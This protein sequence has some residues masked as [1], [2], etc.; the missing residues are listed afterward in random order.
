MSGGCIRSLGALGC[1]GF[2]RRSNIFSARLEKVER[3]EDMER[4]ELLAI[5]EEAKRSGQISLNLSLRQI[6]EL[7]ES[8]GELT[9]L[10]FLSLGN[11]R[12]T[13]LPESI[14]ELTNLTSLNLGR[15][16]LTVLP[17]SI[18]QLTSLTSLSLWNNRLTILP[19]SMGELINLKSLSLWNNCL[20]ILPESIGELINL[21]SINLTSNRIIVLPESIGELTNL[22]SLNLENNHLTVLSE[23]IGQLSALK[24]FILRNNQLVALPDSIGKLSNL[25]SLD[26]SSNQLIGLPNSIRKLTNLN[27]LRCSYNQLRELPQSIGELT[28]LILLDLDNND[29]IELPESI[30]ELTAL[31]FLS[32]LSNHIEELPKSVRNLQKIT[33]LSFNNRQL[34]ILPE[35]VSQLTSLRSLDLKNNELISIP[36][37]IKN[38]TNLT[39]LDLS[40]NELKSF[41]ES[42]IRLT[43]LASLHL[44]NIHLSVLPESIGELTNLAYLDLCYNQLTALPDSIGQLINLTH[45]NLW[46]NQLI[47]L[48]DSIGSLVKLVDLE[49]TSNQLTKLPETI[50]NLQKLRKLK[51]T[52]NQLVT[53]PESIV[54]LQNLSVLTIT[55]NKLDL[56]VE[57]TRKRSPSAILEFLRQQKEEGT[58]SIYEAKLLIIGEPGAGKTSL[59]NKLINSSYELKLEGSKN[60]EKSTEGIDVLHFDFPHSSG[61]AFRINL[62]DFGGQEIYHATHQFFLTKRSLYLL[63]ADT[64]QDNTDFNY[65]LE[66]VELLSESSPTLII[67][68]EKQDRPCQVNENQLYG[69][70]PNQLKGILPTNLATNRGLSQILTD[71]QHHISQLPHIGTPL[72]KTWVRVREAL[73]SDTRNYITKTEFLDLCNTHGFKRKEDT[74]QLSEYLHDLGVCLHFQDDPI[75]KNWIILKPE[76]GTTAVYTVL[77]TPSVQKALGHFTQTDLVMIWADD[78]YTDMRDELLQLMK[79]FKLCYEIP[80]RPRTYITPQLLSPNQPEYDW[81]SNDN[82][83]LRYKYEFMPKGMLTRFTVEMH[84]LIDGDLVWK[85]GVILSDGNARAE[86]IEAYY[87]NEI[88]IRI[89]GQLKKRLLEKIRHEFDKIHNSYNKPEDPP[90]DHRLRYQEYI[91]CNCSTCKGSQTPHAYALKRLEERLKND[92]QEIECDISYTM[93]SVRDLIDDAIGQSLSNPSYDVDTE[94]GKRYEDVLDLAQRLADRPMNIT[95]EANAVAEQSPRQQIFQAPIGVVANDHAQ[96]SHFTQNN[97]ANVVELLQLISAMRQ[98]AAQF[99]QDIQDDFI[100]DLD[101]VES[102]IKKPE[103]D[104]NLPKIKKRLLAIL[105]AVSLI[106]GSVA[107]MTDFA[108]NAIDVGS[109]LGIELRLP[110][111]P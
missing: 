51:V 18:G 95:A 81:D 60:P 4:S 72:P 104:R 30:G 58:E 52:K 42:I 21:K 71:I 97:N 80:H 50:G 67:K 45:L 92:R 49:L 20:T 63:I 86:I 43:N 8:I 44:G 64:R 84:R 107:G 88:R 103:A 13:V 73:E 53:L 25:T 40:N 28:S 14:G 1:R 74:L 91:P 61:N 11:N 78:Q 5:I 101:D 6:E 19:E 29:L 32:L 34:K 31:T 9:S 108:N 55:S 54:K 65:W 39:T 85:E 105:T 22:T 26:I 62:W 46:Y 90:E 83:I 75:L 87:K 98:T 89:S 10:T 111:A 77:D 57:I 35:W 59:A 109:K 38:L 7:P 12:L 27:S 17:E 110:P 56:P 24:S 33:S 68:N 96:V 93:V 36:E 3:D 70:F 102:E 79:N 41:P 15:N 66:V 100:I 48:P 69:R 106:S 99:P 37:S 82:L 76:W 23:S 16:R 94:N 47:S 2:D